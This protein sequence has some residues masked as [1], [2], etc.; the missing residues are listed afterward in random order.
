L[1]AATTAEDVD[2]IIPETAAGT[3]KALDIGLRTMPI[4]L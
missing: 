1:V 3:T 4:R 2:T